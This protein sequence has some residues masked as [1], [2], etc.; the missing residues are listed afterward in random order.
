MFVLVLKSFEPSVNPEIV[1][2]VMPPGV[3]PFVLLKL[4]LNVS[5]LAAVSQ[6]IAEAPISSKADELRRIW[7]IRTVTR[8]ITSEAYQICSNLHSRKGSLRTLPYGDRQVTTQAT[9]ASSPSS[10]APPSARQG[11]WWS[12]SSPCLG[13][14]TSRWW[15]APPPPQAFLLPRSCRLCV[16]GRSQ[17]R[18]RR[19]LITRVKGLSFETPKEIVGISTGSCVAV[20]TQAIKSQSN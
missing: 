10:L 8:L 19:L 9:L 4:Q 20:R 11:L 13:T 7:G 14:C 18:K 3:E 16:L 6:K 1:P 5:A 15:D 2:E 12:R 17:S